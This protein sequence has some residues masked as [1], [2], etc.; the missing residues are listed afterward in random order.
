MKIKELRI[1]N[2][3]LA[4]EYDFPMCVTGIFEDKVYLNFD[5]NNDDDLICKEI[6][7]M[8]IR[9]TDETLL[10]FGFVKGDIY[11]FIDDFYIDNWNPEQSHYTYNAET[12]KIKYL[13]QLQNLYFSLTGKELKYEQ[14][15]PN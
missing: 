10:K 11:H 2:Y 7:I 8:P 9:L 14:Q 6:E 12:V 4:G 3:V 15:I 13:H 5:G 1:G